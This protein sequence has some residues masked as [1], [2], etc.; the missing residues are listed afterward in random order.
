MGH[1]AADGIFTDSASYTDLIPE[2]SNLSIGYQNEHSTRETLDLNYLEDVIQRL[3]TVDWNAVPVVRV[4]GD[5]GWSDPLTDDELLAD[6]D[7]SWFSSRER[8]WR[9]Q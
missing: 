5:D 1:R 3:I 7:D 9:I 4:P 6:L 8:L 2:C